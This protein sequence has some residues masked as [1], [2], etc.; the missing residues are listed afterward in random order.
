MLGILATDHDH[1]LAPASAAQ[2]EAL[3]ADGFDGC[4]DFHGRG[5]EAGVPG[6]SGTVDGGVPSSSSG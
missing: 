4:A 3:I 2:R 6:G 5:G 1:G